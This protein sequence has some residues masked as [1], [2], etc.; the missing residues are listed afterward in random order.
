V[1]VATPACRATSAIVTMLPLPLWMSSVYL[2]EALRQPSW[3]NGGTSVGEQSWDVYKG[4][5]G[6]N[7]MFSFV[8]TSN[9]AAGTV[10]IKAV[11][12][13]PRS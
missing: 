2:I 12:N 3:S 13:G 5:N 11:M 9:T 10:D 8:R 7:R 4:S 6:S 1:L